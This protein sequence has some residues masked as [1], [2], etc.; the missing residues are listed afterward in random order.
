VRGAEELS[1]LVL[2]PCKMSLLT[3]ITLLAL[4]SSY[5]AVRL[6]PALSLGSVGL[7]AAITVLCLPVA[8]AAASF[9]ARWSARRHL[10][11][12]LSWSGS[13]TL[14][15]VSSLLLLTLLRDVVLALAAWALG[16]GEAYSALR[17]WSAVAVPSLA[18]L[19]TLV[20]LYIAIRP[21]RV[22]EITVPL[23]GLRPELH[24]FTIV[25]VTDLHVGNTIRRGYVERIVQQ[26][27]A[28]DA[29]LIAIT[30]D[31][32][33]GSVTEIGQHVAPLAGLRSR[34][35]TY[36]VTGNH[37]Y[38][39]GAD[40]W[41]AYLRHLGI[42]VLL[43]EHV[44]IEHGAAQ[45]LLAGITDPVAQAFDRTQRSD[46]QTAMRGAPAL[47]RPRILLAH[48]PRSAVLA[49]R[50][51]F[52]LQLSGHT[53]GGQFWPWNLVVRYREPL[54]IGL[55]RLNSLWV[56]SSRGT[57]FW[58]PPQRLGVPSEITRLHLV[59]TSTRAVI[60]TPSEHATPAVCGAR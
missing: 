23:R 46:P 12:L 39:S 18:V 20:G 8:L 21:P 37:E 1:R 55:D 27:N 19:A 11:R 50:A 4:V 25:Q 52:D 45:L 5:L 3:A 47:L 30:G 33:D 31:L 41:V 48:R 51:G 60:A 44:I 2:V 40:A 10:A 17:M 6:L 43:N 14:G 15:W 54:S 58:G 38:Y 36:F 24:G 42:N 29:D 9:L 35:G 34:H 49:E 57:G 13:L 26:V 56:Y 32:V 53:H 16:R 28:L 59:P 22:R 7:S